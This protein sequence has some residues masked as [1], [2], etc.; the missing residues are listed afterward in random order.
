M[1]VDYFESNG[2]VL[3]TNDKPYLENIVRI[4]RVGMMYR[5]QYMI[6]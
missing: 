3:N 2:K 5:G 1:L 6:L 4:S